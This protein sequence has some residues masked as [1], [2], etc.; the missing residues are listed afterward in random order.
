MEPKYFA[1]TRLIAPP[2]R[3]FDLDFSLPWHRR[4]GNIVYPVSGNWDFIDKLGFRAIAL[5]D[6]NVTY[7]QFRQEENII[8]YPQEEG[9]VFENSQEML[10]S[11]YPGGPTSGV[12]IDI[13]DA[14]EEGD[15]IGPDCLYPG[16]Y[17]T[18]IRGSSTCRKF[19]IIYDL[20]Q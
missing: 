15:Y 2:E 12:D 7:R 4:D 16:G 11:V 10:S 9:T 5:E 19:R 13:T 14:V 1:Q 8:Y 20:R 6:G 3:W 18:I 17:L